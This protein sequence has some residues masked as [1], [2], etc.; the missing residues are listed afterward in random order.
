MILAEPTKYGSGI[1]IYGDALDLN[2][3]YETIHNISESPVLKGK[4]NDYIL[5]FA[6]DIR[7]AKEATKEK[8]IMGFDDF[9]Q[10]VTY[11]GVK[12]LWPDF[13]FFV[14]LLRWASGFFP[15]TKIHQS[16]LYLLE[17]FAES[18]LTSYD[19]E[20]GMK[21]Y[22]WLVNFIGIRENYLVNFI[23]EQNKK[24]LSF[25]DG[26]TRFKNLPNILYSL[27]SFSPEY[28]EFEKE[29]LKISIKNN[30]DPLDI[31]SE[32]QININFKW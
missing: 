31:W 32:E 26:K 7:K 14:G 17:H 5:G 13:L 11:L 8:I 20:S 25:K 18:C 28:K 6:Y 29:I 24:F 1:K 27:D 9:D 16:Y 30:C 21:S 22:N 12:I 10:K 2:S 15:T 19:Y 3:L 23:Y 4:L